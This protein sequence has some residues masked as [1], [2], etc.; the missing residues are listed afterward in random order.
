MKIILASQSPRRHELLKAAGFEFD[1]I[2]ATGEENIPPNTPPEQAVTALAEQKAA[3]IAA[4]YPDSDCTVIG[5]DTIVYL[6]GEIL[7]KPADKDDA[8][9]MLRKLS[10]KLH[11]V[12]TGVAVIS[13]RSKHTFF[14]ET[15]VEF[16]ELSDSEIAAYID[17]GEPFDKAGAYGIQEKGMLLV[18]Q[19]RGDFYNVMG[20]PISRLARVLREQ[21][22]NRDN[23]DKRDKRYGISDLLGIMSRLR[24]ECPWDREQTHASIRANVIEEAYEVAEAI[25]RGSAAELC[26]ESGDLLLQVVFH[27]QIA[28]EAGEYNF[29]DVCDGICRKLIYRHPHVFSDSERGASST[30]DD[31]LKNWDRLKSDGAKAADRLDSV[32]KSLPALLRGEKVGKRAALAGFDFTEVSQTLDCLES[33][34]EELKMAVS[35]EKEARIEEEF[36]DVLF[37]CCNLGRI[38]KKDCEKALTL[39]INRFIMR[40]RELEDMVLESGR[41]IDSLSTT[42]LD[43][44]WQLAK[45]AC[46]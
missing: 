28:S 42:Q 37:S 4:L 21:H 41:T 30:A 43:E 38:L 12:F 7:G 9:A 11:R 35:Q 33:E 27:A 24:V 6:D 19:I 8:F 23:R 17:T 29:D 36:G 5:A 3:E 2:P 31:V 18:K 10:G 20:L 45:K 34:I 25:D 1:I 22:D 39:S 46:T 44:L 40:F 16:H 14:E 15:T 26:E 32:P 13:N